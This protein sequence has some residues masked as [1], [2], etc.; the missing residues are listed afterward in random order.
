MK[1]KRWLAILL[2][3]AQVLALLA[4]PVFADESGGPGGPI[5]ATMPSDVTPVT[6]TAEETKL[7]TA[8]WQTNGYA[9]VAFTAAKD[10]TYTIFAKGTENSSEDIQICV[11]VSPQTGSGSGSGEENGTLRYHRTLTFNATKSETYTFQIP[12]F[13][14]SDVYVYVS[15]GGFGGPGPGGP[16][17]ATMPS[18]VTPVTVTAEETKLETAAWQTNGYAYVAFTAAKD[19]T[20]TIFAKGT[21]SSNEGIQICEDVSPQMGSGSGHDA[22]AGLYENHLT[23][24]ANAGDEY[25]FQIPKF[26]SSD[27]YVYVSEGGFGGPG[28]QFT[29]TT[30]NIYVGGNSPEGIQYAEKLTGTGSYV[31]GCYLGYY[32]GT[33]YKALSAED[34]TVV[35]EIGNDIDG[36]ASDNGSIVAISAGDND[37]WNFEF[38]R[39]TTGRLAVSYLGKTHYIPVQ[40]SGIPEPDSTAPVTIVPADGNALTL[41]NNTTWI[42][43]IGVY[44]YLSFTPAADGTYTIYAEAT[45]K[46]TGM[47][48]SGMELCGDEFMVVESQGGEA[49]DDSWMAYGNYTMKA[50]TTYYIKLIAEPDRLNTITVTGKLS[51]GSGYSY[52]VPQLVW[53][54]AASVEE[55]KILTAIIDGGQVKVNNNLVAL[56]NDWYGVN[57]TVTPTVSGVYELA[58]D[59]PG[60]YLN[61]PTDKLMIQTA[62]CVQ[63]T[64]WV[65]GGHIVK[66]QNAAD[67]QMWDRFNLEAGK[68]YQFQFLV[69]RHGIDA[70]KDVL[71]QVESVSLKA[72]NIS[73]DPNGGVYAVI[74]G[75]Y[76]QKD[77]DE[78]VTATKNGVTI[79][80]TS[81]ETNVTD[82]TVSIGGSSVESLVDNQ[83]S[84]V[85]ISTDVADVTFDSTALDTINDTGKNVALS[86]SVEETE[87]GVLK[88]ELTLVD[89]EGNPVL[90][91]ATAATNGTVTVTI[92]YEVP[93]GKSIQ[94]YYVD[95]EG[96]QTRM[97]ARYDEETG[98]ITFE[99]NHFS[100]Y[101]IQTVTDPCNGKHTFTKYTETKAATCTEKGSEAAIC[102]KCKTV[103]DTREIAAT[104]HSWDS[105]KV[106][107]KATCTTEGVKTYS[108][109]CGETK[110]EKIAA[111]RHSYDKSVCTQC[112]TLK[113]GCTGEEGCPIHDYTDVNAAAWYH[114]DGYIDYVVSN[115][116]MVGTSKQ[117]L[118]FE[119]EAEMTR[120]HMIQALWNLAGKPKSDYKPRFTDVKETSWYYPALAWA[121]EK[122]LVKGLPDGTFAP[123]EALTR[124]QMVT[125][126]YRYAKLEGKDTCASEIPDTFSDR[127]TI[128]PFAKDA[129]A[130]AIDRGLINGMKTTPETLAPLMKAER[131]QM[132]KILTVYL[133]ME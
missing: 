8:A 127:D 65:T 80:A 22:D 34:V 71:L 104:G 38:Q 95:D 106:T 130:W 31:Q 112:G 19:G 30:D 10:G 83:V 129:F 102:D 96:N 93:A 32:D 84:S 111:T 79:D 62:R 116:I 46:D 77:S 58:L 113:T 53:P 54:A 33:D 69:C 12:K 97:N 16:M 6:V 48:S 28:G 125:F 1:V 122:E 86:V 99:T 2:C 42:D 45:R 114:R 11:D 70:S 9:Y 74:S 20:Y 56:T 115:G 61:D 105:G 118:S 103:I 73:V 47:I 26:G 14:S 52:V 81:D 44:T 18:G 109:A 101:E 64:D 117:I 126:L 49:S 100:L 78:T 92:P 36:Y 5:A 57:F 3:I 119:P 35:Y 85:T 27:V 51:D 7:E 82:V 90:P 128:M 67:I 72:D 63:A 39:A 15:E 91:D 68:T 89:S 98:L 24:N 133:T 131:A 23:F 107:K 121:C 76:D 17:A 37:S 124:D 29:P 25:V 40:I 50:G 60:G 55:G 87:S 132:A 59:I 120:A 88:V 94:V 123:D 110:T 21:E 75:T 41:D 4:V 108:C 66:Q 13:G 43:E